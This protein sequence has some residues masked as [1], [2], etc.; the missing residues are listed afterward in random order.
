MIFVLGRQLRISDTFKSR[1]GKIEVL[2]SRLFGTSCIRG[3]VGQGLSVD[4]VISGLRS[5]GIDVID[6][7][8]LLTPA[9]VFLTEDMRFDTGVPAIR[10][11]AESTSGAG[12]EALLTKGAQTVESILKR[13]RI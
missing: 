13:L 2:R 5:S 1:S 9:L 3:I 4:A 11:R 10:V 7:G 12:T 8:I 6:I